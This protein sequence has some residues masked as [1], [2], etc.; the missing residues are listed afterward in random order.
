[1]ADSKEAQRLW[2]EILK[3]EA[4]PATNPADFAW[5]QKEMQ[6]LRQA[7]MRATGTSCSPGNWRENEL[8]GDMKAFGGIAGRPA[9]NLTAD[10][11]NNLPPGYERNRKPGLSGGR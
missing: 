5:K 11:L 9:E 10:D 8:K 1:M 2:S 3:L 6:S 4:V 7:Y